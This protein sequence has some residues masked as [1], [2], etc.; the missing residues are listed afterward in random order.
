MHLTDRENEVLELVLS[1]MP[2][3]QISREINLSRQRVHAI[4]NRL[5][6]KNFQ[7]LKLQ[8]V[9]KLRTAK[10]LKLYRN[11]IPRPQIIAETN[12]SKK[13]VYDATKHLVKPI[14]QKYKEICRLKNKGFTTKFIA[15]KLGVTNRHIYYIMRKYNA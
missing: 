5:R 11:G 10:V 1:G 12:I 7:I 9:I 15:D 14:P 4:V 13:N 3:S 2:I 6:D 8:D